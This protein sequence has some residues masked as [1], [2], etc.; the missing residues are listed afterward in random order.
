MNL[1]LIN[2]LIKIKGGLI[3]APKELLFLSSVPK[4]DGEPY[5]EMRDGEIFY[6]SNERGYEI[7]RVK[8]SDLDDLLYR[9][10]SRVTMKLATEY[11]LKNRDI[12]KDCRRLIFAQ[13]L[14][15]L[16][17]LNKEWAAREAKKIYLILKEYPYVDG[18]GLN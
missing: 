11:E 9:V 4:S 13:Q 17:A 7:F 5:I 3:N 8:I 18:D 16:R 10:F 14:V 2:E 15:L 1:E 12:G 6:V